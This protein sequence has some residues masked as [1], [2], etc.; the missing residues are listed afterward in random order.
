M[1]ETKPL[2]HF[3]EMNMGRSLFIS[4]ARLP[5]PTP[6]CR[7]KPAA[8]LIGARS[9]SPP[10]RSD[11]GPDDWQQQTLIHLSLSSFSQLFSSH[12]SEIRVNWL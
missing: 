10:L 4:P 8:S 1:I 5:P 3:S 11:Y 12:P 6:L 7:S 9:A 2:K